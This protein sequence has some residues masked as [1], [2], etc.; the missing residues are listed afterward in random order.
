MGGLCSCFGASDEEEQEHAGS[1]DSLS[2]HETSPHCFQ[3]LMTYNILFQR[4]HV[5]PI[6][7]A[8]Q[9]RATVV[10]SSDDDSIS[11]TYQPPPRPLPYD[12]PSC[13]VLRPESQTSASI[14]G[15][16][17]DF[18]KSDFDGDS[19]KTFSD[20]SDEQPL[21]QPRTGFAYIFSQVEDE[22]V[23]PTCLEDIHAG[24]IGRDGQD[25]IALRDEF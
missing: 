3:F 2:G 18:K 17:E 14:L 12:D 16:A 7:S 22:D 24:D 1:V 9:G 4:G 5:R 6:S 20:S 10:P 8:H 21:K 15:A 13:T 11:D 23:C 19:K 25:L